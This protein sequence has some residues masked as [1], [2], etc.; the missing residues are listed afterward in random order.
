MGS[1]KPSE[2]AWFRIE[3][4]K[5]LLSG[6]TQADVYVYG[7][8]VDVDFWGDGI[9]VAAQE[10]VQQIAAL[11]VGQ[12]NLYVNS[13]GGDV[14]AA[15]A[16]RNALARHP[17]NV[18]ATVDGLAASAASFLLTGANDVV[19]SPNA[20][21]MIHD[22]W[23][24]ARGDAEDL[25][26][27]ADN[28]DR[29]SMNLASMY[30]AKAGGTPEDWRS[31]MQA[32]TWYSADEAVI[33][34]LADRVDRNTDPQQEDDPFDL[35]AF[36]Y[37]GRASAPKP[38]LKRIAAMRRAKSAPRVLDIEDIPT[39][40]EPGETPQDAA[41]I[42]EENA[43]PEKQAPEA[44]AEEQ[45]QAPAA[46]FDYKAMAAAFKEAFGQEN[47]R[48]VFPVALERHPGVGT[49]QPVVENKGPSYNEVMN[50]FAARSAGRLPE[51]REEVLK[52]L[53][54]K[55]ANVFAALTDIGL[56][57]AV[58]GGLVNTNAPQWIGELL[59][60]VQFNG[61]WNAIAHDDLTQPT[62]HGFQLTTFPTGG[63]KGDAGAAVTSTGAKWSPVT[64]DAA[65]WAGA[66]SFDRTPFDFGISASALSSYFR[67]QLYNYYVWRDQQMIN[68]MTAGMTATVMGAA[69]TGSSI[70]PVT[71]QILDG[72]VN[73]L[74]QGGGIANL[75]VLPVVLFKDLIKNSK[76]QAPAF[77]KLDLGAVTQGNIEGTL[78]IRPDLSGTVAA[79]D[80]L[81][82]NGTAGIT[83]YELPGSPVRAEQVQVSIG[84][85]D[86]GLFG[87]IAAIRSSAN[88]F[89]LVSQA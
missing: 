19:M 87:Y 89:S 11:D 8:I 83:G 49:T 32:E 41:P 66:D 69:P 73:V 24:F 57:D 78:S 75:A 30:A 48:P 12:I 85:I 28:L 25:R 36:A 79:G 52:S 72:V 64:V 10:F 26:A 35:S 17:A 65:R 70:D 45:T 51:G 5:A 55:S 44:P 68:A 37:Q 40:P 27:E 1:K 74:N 39:H 46:A 14:Y 60:R 53:T 9:D 54:T 71:N 82:G 29:V 7:D 81:V 3:A 62:V 47:E 31:I 86:V 67:A 76:L 42:Q 61:I 4:P 2:K 56:A 59:T 18:T 13:P 6:G 84:N 33:A 23:S 58:S 38:P 21:L 88:F 50:L 80:V 34:G 20:E 16:M 15:I 77:L 43:M 22:A 63:T